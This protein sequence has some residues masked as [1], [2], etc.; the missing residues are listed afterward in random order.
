MVSVTAKLFKLDDREIPFEAG[1]TIIQAATRAGVDIPHYCWHPGLSVAANCRM[2]LVEMMPPPGRKAM[3]LEVARFDS[4]SGTYVKEQKPK[5]VPACQQSVAEGMDIRSNSSDHVIRARASVQEFLLLNHP[6][7]CP[8]CDQAGECRLQDYWLEHQQ[9]K[10][11]MRDEPVHKPKAVVFGP[12][13]VYD[14][15]RCIACT[16]CIRFCDEVAKDPV[17]TLRQ[18]GNL[19]EIAVAPG[20][21]LDNAY[22]LMTEH[23][24]PVGALTARDF[25]FKARVWFLRSAETICTGCARGC[26]SYTDYDPRQQKVYRYRPRTNETVNKH[27]MCDDGMLSYRRI[28][29][30]RITAS[31]VEGQV[32]EDAQAV[33][34]AVS[35]LRGIDGKKLAILMGSEFSLED[36]AVL[37]ALG[38]NLGAESFFESGQPSGKFDQVL[39]LADKNPNTAGV[40]ALLDTDPLPISELAQ[41]VSSGR[42]THVLSLGTTLKEREAE[43]SLALQKATRIAIGSH[44][45]ALAEGANVVLAVACWAEAEGIFVNVGGLAQRSSRAVL[46]PSGLEPAHQVIAAVAHALGQG[47]K[48]LSLSEIRATIDRDAREL[49]PGTVRLAR[50]ALPNLVERPVLWGTQLGPSSDQSGGVQ[51]GYLESS[52]DQSSQDQ[53]SQDQSIGKVRFEKNRGASL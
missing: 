51:S 16:R 20:R 39:M 30:G 41:G 35:L 29:E 18:R 1:D 26:N 23:V 14:A 21:Q 48:Q 49:A 3:M 43:E 44:Q 27:W 9:T 22:T 45:G 8:I 53:S 52:L 6:V 15:E 31:S 25:R 40:Q 10:K 11:R 7:D 12:T 37:L 38:R 4:A 46:P 13:I 17:L 5:L 36:N 47:P 32:V 42:F 24:C 34:R 33:E 19:N 28:T 50:I 2:C